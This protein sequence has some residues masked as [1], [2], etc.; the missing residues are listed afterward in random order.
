[1]SFF[2]FHFEK[3]GTHEGFL[4]G[5]L[6]FTDNSVLEFREFVDTESKNDRLMYTYHYQDA[7][8]KL[9]FRYDNTGHHKKLNLPTYPHHK[10]EGDE[11]NVVAAKAMDLRKMLNEIEN[12]ISF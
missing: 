6:V 9:I 3:R 11:K 1:V 4:K 2:D 12:F 7:R 10:H 8:D 5:R